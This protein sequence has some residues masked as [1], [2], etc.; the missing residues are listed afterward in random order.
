MRILSALNKCLMAAAI[1]ATFACNDD[2]KGTPV[3]P[4]LTIPTSYDTT[5][6]LANTSAERAVQDDLDSLVNAVKEG[7]DVRNVLNAGVLRSIYT[8]SALP[9]F[10]T[11]AEETE[12]KNWLDAVATASGRLYDPFSR[13]TG[14]T[15]GAYLFS[16]TGY[17]F[18]QL[19]DKAAFNNVLYRHAYD[20]S[21]RP[22]SEANVD[23]MAR[24][25]GFTAEFGNDGSEKYM[26]KYA[27]RRDKADGNGLYTQ[28]K[29]QIII[30][31]AAAKA[32]S[33]YEEEYKAAITDFLETWE[34]AS[35]ATAINY[36][37]TTVS[38]L[39][40]SGL[41]ATERAAALHAY[42]EAIG[43]LRGFHSTQG[44][45]ITDAQI[46]EIVAL[47]LFPDDSYKLVTESFASLPKLTEA[48]EKL[49]AIYGFS[50]AEMNDFAKNWVSEQNR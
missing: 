2:G 5:S 47:A 4:A 34:K 10:Q 17:E 8:N 41:T 3:K 43:F 19:I 45:I 13:A 50:D 15:Y 12:I 33:D 32:G 39:S 14:G 28:A 26:A 37:K 20:L 16:N 24:A 31:Q 42:S 21:Q 48:N 44:T 18:E 22:M 9:A 25:F 6:Y 11:D 46:N 36:F 29:N 23:G 27:A 7:R 40:S 30:A 38:T 35:A 49:Q 1:V